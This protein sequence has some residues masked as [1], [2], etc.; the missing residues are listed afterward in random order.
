MNLGD[1]R[2]ADATTLDAPVGDPAAGRLPY[3]YHQPVRHDGRG[4]TLQP[5]PW[6]PQRFR[7]PTYINDHG[8]YGAPAVAHNTRPD[9][10]TLGIR[11]DTSYGLLREITGAEY[12]SEHQNLSAGS[13]TILP[14]QSPCFL[15]GFRAMGGY[16][17]NHSVT[18][19]SETLTLDLYAGTR[20]KS[21]YFKTGAFWDTQDHFGKVGLTF[22]A[23]SNLPILGVWTVDSAFAFGSGADQFSMP[24]VA[25]MSRRVETADLDA[26]IRLGRYL[27]P[28]LQLGCTGNYSTYD[29]LNEEWG[30]GAFC[31]LTFGRLRITLD[32]TGG[33]EGL[34][35]FTS[36]A[37][38]FGKRGCD[39][40]QDCRYG[41]I[42]TVSW[43]SRV[44][45]RDPSIRLRESFTGPFLP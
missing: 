22:S 8:Y 42:D 28:C 38:S 15:L 13:V 32:V 31:N 33:D 14:Y 18:D 36:F 6:G 3:Q 44:A 19:D 10:H 11:L 21:L 43:V 17:D 26:Q 30:A 35:G 34:R 16:A 7:L 29:F 24:N 5:D 37:W 12:L 40:P 1:V 4:D 45:D 39:H 25:F 27:T 2:H 20:Y 9:P 23:M 41:A